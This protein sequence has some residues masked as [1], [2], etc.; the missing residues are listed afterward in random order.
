MSRGNSQQVIEYALSLVLDT[1]FVAYRHLIADPWP[2]NPQG[3]S[4]FAVAGE[5]TKQFILPACVSETGYAIDVQ[6]EKLG[7][8]AAP[9]AGEHYTVDPDPLR[10]IEVVKIESVSGNSARILF[11]RAHEAGTIATRSYPLWSSHRRYSLV[12]V[13]LSAAQDAEKRRKVNDL[14]ARASKGVS[15]W[16]IVSDQGSFILDSATRG[17]LGSTTLA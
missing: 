2:Y 14:M 4:V 5:I 17:I 1:D 10:T 3:T 16:A 13:S 9:L 15:Q 12:V 6:F 11:Q 7:D 8:S